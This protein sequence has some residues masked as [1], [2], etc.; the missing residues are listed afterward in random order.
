MTGAHIHSDDGATVV[1][2]LRTGGR[3][4]CIDVVP[5]AEDTELTLS[6]SEL[7]AIAADPSGYY[8]DVHTVRYPDGAISGSLK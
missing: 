6:E 3:T 7:A 1:G 4:V 5:D 8:V 2:L